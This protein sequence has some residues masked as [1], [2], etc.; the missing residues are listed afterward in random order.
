MELELSLN[1]LMNGF[2]SSF[3]LC[4]SAPDFVKDLNF[5][6]STRTPSGATMR[7]HLQQNGHGE[8]L[9]HFMTHLRIANE[10]NGE[11]FN[12]I[13]AEIPSVMEDL[14]EAM[15]TKE[16]HDASRST[17]NDLMKKLL[18]DKWQEST[19]VK[20]KDFVEETKIEAGSNA[21]AG[22]DVDVEHAQHM[23]EAKKAASM[24]ASEWID[25]FLMEYDDLPPSGAL[26]LILAAMSEKIHD[27]VNAN[28]ALL[29]SYGDPDSQV[30]ILSFIFDAIQAINLSVFFFDEKYR[31][32][33]VFLSAER[34]RI[35]CSV[36]GW[37]S[38]AVSMCLSDENNV[39]R[40]K[41]ARVDAALDV[42]FDGVLDALSRTEGSYAHSR[43]LKILKSRIEGE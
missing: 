2:M 19:D 33:D 8:G 23:A 21:G 3:M 26:S 1:D 27:I 24:D 9:E 6:L 28:D 34:N 15:A 14:A 29:W 32:S 30:F 43:A 35:H 31:G 7:E 41:Q 22:A 42:I 38:L 20:A 4:S 39:K 12:A 10:M 17:Y 40:S 18:G 36:A 11:K 13:L 16:D 5:M 37:A 25:D